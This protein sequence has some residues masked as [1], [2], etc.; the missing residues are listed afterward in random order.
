MPPMETLYSKSCGTGDDFCLDD[1]QHP[2]RLIQFLVGQRG[3][4]EP[5]AIGGAWS[6]SLDGPNPQDDP[7]VLIRTAVRT[8]L[9]LTGIDLS[10][11]SKW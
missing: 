9:A 6:P 3:R 10:R 5:M 7:G 8:V 1:M 2:A 11:C 4:N